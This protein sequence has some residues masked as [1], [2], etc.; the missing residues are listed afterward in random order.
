MPID[1]I[2]PTVGTRT[3]HMVRAST[4]MVLK[5]GH[6]L[7]GE[8]ATIYSAMGVCGTE[9]TGTIA[10]TEMA[11]DVTCQRCAG[12]A[13]RELAPEPIVSGSHGWDSAPVLSSPEAVQEP[14]EALDEPTQEGTHRT[15]G[16]IRHGKI[17]YERSQAR[18]KMKQQLAGRG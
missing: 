14:D 5:E 11:K 6:G 2:R 10:T 1:V 9:A 3:S 13:Q 18:Q 8:R 4:E 7:D 16:R 15:A 12:R 17:R